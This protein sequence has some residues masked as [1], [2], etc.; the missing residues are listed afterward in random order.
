MDLA[1]STHKNQRKNDQFFDN[2]WYFVASN[3][4]HGLWDVV[5]NSFFDMKKIIYK[6]KID[7][8]TAASYSIQY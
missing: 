1:H 8:F 6:S 7:E 2:A 4:T 3:W 5:V